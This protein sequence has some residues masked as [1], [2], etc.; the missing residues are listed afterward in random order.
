[1]LTVNVVMRT[2]NNEDIIDKTLAALFSQKGIQFTLIV[3]DSGSTDN[4]L[5]LMRNYPKKLITIEN[6]DYIPG[7]VLNLGVSQCE[8]EIIVFLN[9]DTVMLQTNTLLNLCNDFISRNLDAGYGRQVARPDAYPEVEKAY[10]KS[11]PRSRKNKCSW[12]T[13]SAPIMIM[14][15]QVALDNKFYNESWGSEDTELGKRLMDNGY[16]V[17]YISSALA[18]HS[19][20]YTLKQLRNRSY[21]EGE[22]DHFIYNTKLS[23]LQLLKLILKRILSFIL[24]NLKA[25]NMR[26]FC[27]WYPFIEVLG[28]NKGVNAAYKRRK[29]NNKQ[30]NYMSYQ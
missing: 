28:Y 12:I 5:Y 8:S 20:N 23:W 25:Q 17:D 16:N 21:I 26:L 3:I 7:K 2:Y 13:L 27:I 22:A 19:H 10:L 6:K 9:S 14:K 18:M 30:L 24:V 1:M 4:T 15:K 29:N 11:F